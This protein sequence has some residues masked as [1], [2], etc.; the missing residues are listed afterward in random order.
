MDKDK[1]I[2]K[3]EADNKMYKK[4]LEK[5]ILLKFKYFETLEKITK[6]IKDLE[7]EEILSF[8]DLPLKDNV[9]MIISQCNKGYVEILKLIDNSINK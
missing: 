5:E 7:K 3:I 1:I 9:Q 2:K 6:I 4:D 8:P